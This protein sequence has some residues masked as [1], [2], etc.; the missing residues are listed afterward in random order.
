MLRRRFIFAA[1]SVC[2][3][4]AAP[5][6]IPAQS[7]VFG[8][9]NPATPVAPAPLLPPEGFTDENGWTWPGTDWKQVPP[10]SEGFSGNGSM[11]CEVF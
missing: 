11:P 8:S 2:S 4:V 7:N 3:L 9:A 6:K 10:E 1:L 5:L